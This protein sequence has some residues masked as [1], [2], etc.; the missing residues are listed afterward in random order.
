MAQSW[1]EKLTGFLQE[2]KET[3]EY[4]A[5]HQSLILLKANPQTYQMVCEYRKE[6]FRMSV[7]DPE[8][9]MSGSKELDDKYK[10]MWE[11]P[12]AAVF[13]ENELIMC[14]MVRTIKEL[15]YQNLDLDIDFLD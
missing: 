1:N 7:Y 13:L 9:W 8:R 14:K 12:N 2:M 10:T 6:S 3:D 5:Y 4:Q 11:D 15:F